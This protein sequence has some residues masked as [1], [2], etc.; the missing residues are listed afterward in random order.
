MTISL[1]I[2]DLQEAWHDTIGNSNLEDVRDIQS[3]PP[4]SPLGNN[5]IYDIQCIA[6]RL[7]A[8]AP[9]QI[10]KLREPLKHA[11]ILYSMHIRS[12]F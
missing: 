8:K 3:A 11:Y 7:V 2:S 9:Q 10:G 6:S 4:D 12:Y 5:M 1:K